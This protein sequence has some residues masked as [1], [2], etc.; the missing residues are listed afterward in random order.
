MLSLSV[1]NKHPSISFPTEISPCKLYY[2]PCFTDY[3]WRNSL[4]SNDG[5][6]KKRKSD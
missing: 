5:I 1:F 3:M 2:F 4:F 6:I